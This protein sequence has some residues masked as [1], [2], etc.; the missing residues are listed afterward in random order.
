MIKVGIIGGSGYTAGELL[1]LLVNHGD[2][3]LDFVFSTTN[4][5]VQI[6]KQHRD[7]VGELDLEFTDQVN[8]NVDVVFLCLGHGRSRSFL[9]EN[10][11]SDTTKVIDLG[12]DFRL[13]ED[14]QYM[15]R[16]FVYGLPELQKDR[17]KNGKNIANPGCF[18]TAIQLGLLPLASAKKIIDTVHVNATTGSTGAGV[19]PGSTT[20]FSWRDNNFSSYKV[21]SHQH[22]G[23][24]EQSLQQLQTSFT[25]PIFFIPNR[26]NF[27]KG[28]Y[29]TIYTK[30]EG[31]EEEAKELYKTYYADAK[32]TVVSD[33]EVNLKQVVNTNKC[34]LHITKKNGMLL[35]TSVIDNLIKGASGQAI[36]NMNLMFGLEEK[37]GLE[38]K[39]S[40]F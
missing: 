24:I 26:G 29:A 3:I 33:E 38:L 2:V 14:Q 30:Y 4:A 8:P 17:I 7:L 1:R 12:N 36:H 22:L 9:E 5:G 20:H 40:A 37:T 35:I 18:A 6:S 16:D 23:E 10:S 15:N 31:S 21:F 39:A 28:I 25:T 11:F 19:M 34:I 27:S 13:E 32:F